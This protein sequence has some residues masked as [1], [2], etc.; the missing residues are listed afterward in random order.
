[1]FLVRIPAPRPP[2]KIKKNHEKI[3]I[4]A[5]FPSIFIVFPLGKF[6]PQKNIFDLDENIFRPGIFDENPYIFL[7]I[8][9]EF[10]LA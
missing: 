4:L 5:Y 1:M 2:W 8:S 9:S 7:Q 10:D 3:E 6:R